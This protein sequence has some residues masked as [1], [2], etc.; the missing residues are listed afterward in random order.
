MPGYVPLGSLDSDGR[1]GTPRTRGAGEDNGP[2]RNPDQA[3]RRPHRATRPRA[4]SL[5]DRA[6]ERA[7]VRGDGSRYRAAGNTNRERETQNTG[8][9]H[10]TEDGRQT[11][12]QTTDPRSEARDTRPRHPHAPRTVSAHQRTRAGAGKWE[13]GHGCMYV[14]MQHAW[15]MLGWRLGRTQEVPLVRTALASSSSPPPPT[16]EQADC[17]PGKY[18][19]ARAAVGCRG[20][21]GGWGG[22]GRGQ[23][24]ASSM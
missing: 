15:C 22:A 16:S 24:L 21:G 11:Q 20:R 23:Q 19:E 18:G 9:A 3:T 12:T 7:R 2:T 17:R 14:C 13:A 5:P 10:P 6:S 1:R 8:T 4:V